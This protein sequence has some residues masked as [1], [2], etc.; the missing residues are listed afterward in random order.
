[1]AL[2]LGERE[3]VARELHDTLLQSLAGIGLQ[4]A[5][6]SK[7]VDTAPAEAKDRLSQ[8]SRLVER[9]V[10]ETRQSV[11]NL[12]AAAHEVPD[13]PTAISRTVTK[14]QTHDGPQ[15][16]F[17]VL[18]KS[19]QLPVRTTEQITRIV[20][21][22]LTNVIA[23]AKATSVR[24]ELAY[25]KGFLRLTVVDDGIGF[26]PS[27]AAMSSDHWGLRGMRERAVSV[28]AQLCIESTLGIGTTIGLSL[29]DTK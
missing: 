7:L 25:E 6:T 5:G 20:D 14:R 11:L 16:S 29:P 2:V 8:L 18:G 27:T 15:V 4:L 10:A 22:A 13:L 12:R 21:E 3:R 28:N 17:A 9:S 23:H 19:R 26:E 24:V 1:M